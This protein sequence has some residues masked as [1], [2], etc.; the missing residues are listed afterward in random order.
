MT[1]QRRGRLPDTLNFFINSTRADGIR[2]GFITTPRGLFLF[3]F[4]VV[5]AERLRHIPCVCHLRYSHS[6][7]ASFCATSHSSLTLFWNRDFAVICKNLIG[8]SSVCIKS[9]KAFSAIMEPVLCKVNW[10]RCCFLN[11]FS[12]SGKTFWRR[13]YLL[14]S[15]HCTDILGPR[16]G[17]ANRLLHWMTEMCFHPDA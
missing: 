16:S 4:F 6:N 8:A 9:S 1:E 14:A 3:E 15:F 11:R 10:N 5:N 2:G 12:G 7:M 17:G 13:D